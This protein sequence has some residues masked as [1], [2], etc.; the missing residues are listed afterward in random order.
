MTKC[1]KC[2]AEIKYIPT[3]HG[4][5][6]VEPEYTEII[7]DDGRASRGHVRHRCPETVNEKALAPPAAA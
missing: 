2:G 6:V 4:V 7:N 5:A 3:R 1:P